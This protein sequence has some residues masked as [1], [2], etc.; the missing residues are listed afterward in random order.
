MLAI[1]FSRKVTQMRT[2]I[3][4]LVVTGLAGCGK[5]EKTKETTGIIPSLN[6]QVPTNAS[7]GAIA[8][9]GDSNVL[10]EHG[11][12]M[13]SIVAHINK[14]VDRLNSSSK[15]EKTGT[16]TFEN[17]SGKKISVSIADGT[18]TYTK[19]AIICTN[20]KPHIFMEWNETVLHM[21]KDWN[22]NP[23]RDTPSNYKA[24]VLYDANASILEIN[25]YGTPWFVPPEILAD[26]THGGS[27]NTE[28]LRGALGSDGSFELQAVRSWDA[29]AVTAF[30]GDVWFSGRLN[31]EG[32]GFG[33]A[34][35]RWNTALCG[36]T[37]FDENAS[38]WCLGLSVAAD[39]SSTKGTAA[40]VGGSFQAASVSKLKAVDLSNVA[41]P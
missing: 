17:E 20:S 21:R 11:E 10:T 27:F 25:G 1:L 6:F 13:E 36:A 34:Y 4:L 8:L 24:E 19:Q 9:A 7:T 16:S 14:V 28:Y 30:T 29:S 5:A 3:Y 26:S 38:N 2:S 15:L 32:I 12:R 22:Q 41:C 37:T 23:W 18:G 40:S 35:R 39:G 33:K 31:A